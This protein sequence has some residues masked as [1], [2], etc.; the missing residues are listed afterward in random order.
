VARAVLTNTGTNVRVQTKIETPKLLF[1][2]TSGERCK[3]Q[4]DA[5]LANQ[6]TIPTTPMRHGFAVR[7]LA[8]IPNQGDSIGTNAIAMYL[9]GGLEFISTVRFYQFSYLNAKKH[10][11]APSREPHPGTPSKKA[12]QVMSP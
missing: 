11:G 10:S 12:G 9:R 3:Y 1:L 8:T 7:S 5:V 2:A 4:I 6:R